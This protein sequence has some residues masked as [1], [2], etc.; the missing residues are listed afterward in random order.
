MIRLY[1]DK[2]YKTVGLQSQY[3]SEYQNIFK[4]F[5]GTKKYNDM[6]NVCSQALPKLKIQCNIQNFPLTFDELYN[7]PQI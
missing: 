3:E 2:F 7:K 5:I 6:V 4:Q 1:T